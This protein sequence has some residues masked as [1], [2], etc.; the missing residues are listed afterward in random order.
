MLPRLPRPKWTRVTT[1]SI[2][3]R[4][5]STSLPQMPVEKSCDLLERLFA[6]RRT[7]VAI[8]G[9]VR[10]ALEYVQ[11]CLDAGLAQFA[12]HAD[13]IAEQEIACSAEQ[14]GGREGA[15][16]AIDG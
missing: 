9:A 15:H 10:L 11:G 6:L 12:M 7:G 4:Q 3:A 5:F 8:P 2:T 1:T 13:R 14:H 16:V